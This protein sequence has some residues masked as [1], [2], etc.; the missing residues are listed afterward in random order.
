[1][2][3]SAQ[4]AV[5]RHR[6]PSTASASR[7]RLPSKYIPLIA[8][9]VVVIT[10]YLTGCF[11]YRNFFRLSVAM[12]LLRGDVYLGVAAI[13]AT[14]VILSGGIDLSVGGLAACLAVFI[15]KMVA[16]RGMPPA[17]AIAL[18]LLLGCLF[19][20]AQGCIIHFYKQPAFLVTLA[21]MFLARGVGFIMSAEPINLAHH[22]FYRTTISN[23]AIPLG[24]TNMPFSI[25]CYGVIFAVALFVAHQTKF[26]RAVHAIGDDEPSAQL[27]GLSVGRTKIL[28]YTLAGLLSALAAVI[29]TFERSAGDPSDLVG[30]ELDAIAAVVIGGTL[31]S[32]G[33]GFVAGTALG[34]LTLGLI[35]KHV[36][37]LSLNTWWTKIAV[38]LLMLLFIGIQ[39][40]VVALSRRGGRSAVS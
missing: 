7:W 2:T 32:G 21:G 1:M 4:K 10:L 22:P 6:R 26:G 14:F 20:A 39:N 19:G 8:T 3:L 25:L 36:I 16:E 34:V 17:Q 40:I 15:A 37:S 31:L 9:A 11:A 13:G 24:V 5:M 27:M 30:F 23:L 12:N 29:Y 35:Q 28:V 18:T 33:V 38:G